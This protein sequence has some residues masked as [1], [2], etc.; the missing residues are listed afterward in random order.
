VNAIDVLRPGPL[1]TVQDLGR[2]GMAAL[3]VGPSG[4]ADR[5][6]ATLAN[7]LV[8]NPEGAACLESTFG[9]LA[10]RFHR[11]A[12]VAVTGAPCPITRNLRSRL[13]REAMNASFT[14]GADEEL[15]FGPPS[16]GLRTYLAVRGGI[17]VPPTLDSRATDV[18]SGLGPPALS[19]GD[20]LP[21]GGEICGPLPP[22]QVAP[23]RDPARELAVVR[24]LL[25]PREDWF[26]PEALSTLANA[27]YEVTSESNRIGLRL[28]GPQLGRACHDEL[29][30]EGMVA[31]AIQVPPSGLPVVFLADHPVTGGYPVIAVVLAEDLP[32][33]AQARPGQA[34]VFRVVN[35]AG[36]VGD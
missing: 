24:V 7:R 22:V 5:R 25:G 29:P 34:V 27:R 26:T 21:I 14:V 16:S 32:V 13:V 10:L 19:T 1:T 4:A 3:G 33:V 15:V 36:R 28:D 11:A 17:A 9:G 18:L 30:S 8:G 23:V 6:S 31:G 12:T 2:P 35:G 20:S